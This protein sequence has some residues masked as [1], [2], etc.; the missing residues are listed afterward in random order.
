MSQ[1]G[2]LI[3][4]FSDV[5]TNAA[6]VAGAAV[7]LQQQGSTNINGFLGVSIVSACV[8]ALPVERAAGVLGGFPVEQAAATVLRCVPGGR[9]ALHAGPQLA[10][11]SSG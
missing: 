6:M 7:A 3:L 2:P 10:A 1:H 5:L 11:G 9:A 8:G 4:G